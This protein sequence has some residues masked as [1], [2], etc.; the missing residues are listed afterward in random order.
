MRQC[1]VFRLL[2][3]TSPASSSADS[4]ML[5]L[6]LLCIAQPGSISSRSSMQQMH[7]LCWLWRRRRSQTSVPTFYTSTTH[8]IVAP[9]HPR[10][11][12][13]ACCSVTDRLQQKTSLQSAAK[14]LLSTVQ[15]VPT[16][17]RHA[18]SATPAQR[19]WSTHAC[20]LRFLRS[21]SRAA[22]WRCTMA[23]PMQC[24][25]AGSAQSLQQICTR[26]RHLE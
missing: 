5:I 21:M 26:C 18:V 23:V 22:Q 16:C 13:T 12:S 2:N 4:A 9:K 25:S 15:N 19:P 10:L 3:C 17:Y 8:T 7:N 1:A 20:G 14:I 6:V 11:L 24:S